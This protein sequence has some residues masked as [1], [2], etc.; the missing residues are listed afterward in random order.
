V[1]LIEQVTSVRSQ[2]SLTSFRSSLETTDCHAMQFWCHV[3][4]E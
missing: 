4:R 1:S 3:S 2:G